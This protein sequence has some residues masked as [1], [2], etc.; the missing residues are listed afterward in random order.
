MAELTWGCEVKPGRVIEVPLEGMDVTLSQ[1]ALDLPGNAAPKRGSHWA[2]LYAQC[3]DWP[4]V[5]HTLLH[6]ATQSTL[7][8]SPNHCHLHADVFCCW[9]AV[10]R[11]I[12]LHT[13]TGGVHTDGRPRHT[14]LHAEHLL[15]RPGSYC[16]A[17]QQG[18]RHDA[19]DRYGQQSHLS[20]NATNATSQTWLLSKQM[21]TCLVLFWTGTI[22]DYSEGGD[23]EDEEDE[24]DEEAEEAEASSAEE[25]VDDE[26]EESEAQVA[27]AP[28]P[29]SSKKQK[30]ARGK[31][32]GRANSSDSAEAPAAAATAATTEAP[33]TK[34]QRRAA[35]KAARR[36]QAEAEAAAKQSKSARPVKEVGGAAR[37]DV[38]NHK[39]GLKYVDQEVGRGKRPQAGKKVT[40]R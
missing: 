22:T 25:S 38:V 30:P 3:K 2:T 4:K 35:A 11:A 1:A 27:P 20:T 5:Y 16:D 31:K 23:I 7:H 29:A 12:D 37:R 18:Q 39:S 17:H 34:Q 21:C 10:T 19:F 33:P 36:Q 15:L 32:R 40:I 6:A 28:S 26:D 8:H 9:V 13:A 24:E 14:A